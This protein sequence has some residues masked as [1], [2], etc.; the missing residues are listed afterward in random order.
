MTKSTSIEE[1]NR[2]QREIMTT[3]ELESRPPPFPTAV[4]AASPFRRISQPV[5]SRLALV[6]TYDQLCG[7]AAYTRSLERQL[8]EIFDVTVFD[9]DQYLLRGTH[10]RVRKFGDQHI[11][12]ICREI[13]NYDAVNLQLEHGTLGR[14]CRDIYRRFNWIVRASR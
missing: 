8:G 11:Q 12:D 2:W 10:R 7:I 3:L 6:S 4:I 9:L 14:N 5:R 1:G 13:R